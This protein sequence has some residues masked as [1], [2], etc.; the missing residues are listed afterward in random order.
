VEASKKMQGLASHSA[1]FVAHLFIPRRSLVTS[2]EANAN[3]G[4]FVSPRAEGMGVDDEG[5]GRVARDG[6]GVTRA[7]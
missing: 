2:A 4:T 6:G 1:P 3:R 5:A 7:S